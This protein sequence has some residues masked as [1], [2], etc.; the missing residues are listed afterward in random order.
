VAARFHYRVPLWMPTPIGPEMIDRE[1]VETILRR[2][3][4][5][6]NRGEIAAAANAIMGLGDEWREVD[7]RYASSLVRELDDRAEIRVFRRV[8]SLRRSLS[9]LAAHRH[10]CNVKADERR[11]ATFLVLSTKEQG[12]VA[13]TRSATLPRRDLGDPRR[14]CVPT[15]IKSALAI[16]RRRTI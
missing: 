16:H 3:F 14:R 12:A 2:R 15:T 4:P 13:T 1:K 5:I 10:P 7:W 6:A 11:L 8:N 9:H